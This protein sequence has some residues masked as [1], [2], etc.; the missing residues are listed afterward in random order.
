M[1]LG[2]NI[3]DV[4]C[5]FT[6]TIISADDSLIAWGASPTYGELGLGDLQKSSSVPKEVSK[7]AEMKIPQV[8]MGYS[9]TLLL[10]NTDDEKTKEK[11]DKLNAFVVD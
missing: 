1:K 10:V 8:A 3:T 5:G 4:A 2:W 11:Y 7:M 6:S 9:H